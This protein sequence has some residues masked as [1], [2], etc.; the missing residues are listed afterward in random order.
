M[1]SPALSPAQRWYRHLLYLYPA[2]FRR[3][4]ARE[5]ALLFDDLYREASQ[6]SVGQRHLA[7]TQAYVDTL[8]SAGREQFNNFIRRLTKQEPTMERP[9]STSFLA[10]HRLSLT[11]SATL[12]IGLGLASLVTDFWGYNGP[13]AYA[14]RIITEGLEADGLLPMPDTWD[15]VTASFVADYVQAKYYGDQRADVGYQSRY[16]LQRHTRVVDGRAYT[17]PGLEQ[18]VAWTYA[19]MEHNF[20]PL[21]CSTQPPVAVR[22]TLEPVDRAGSAGVVAAFSYAGSSSP[23][24][25][26]YDLR[27]D[28]S[29]SKPGSWKITQVDCLTL[30]S[31]PSRPYVLTGESTMNKRKWTERLN[32]SFGPTQ[33]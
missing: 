9:S 32:R 17:D 30:D 2:S 23:N 24:L 15:G 3:E 27:L 19:S 16:A 33:P 8:V 1:P 20:D 13:V 22:Y 6:R 31:Q 10:R 21:T 25:V 28:Q 14:K 5:L 11:V 29:Q 7:I 26:R 12:I 4:Y 18:L